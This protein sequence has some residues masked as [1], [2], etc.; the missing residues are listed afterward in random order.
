MNPDPAGTVSSSSLLKTLL[1]GEDAHEREEEVSL[2]STE[3]DDHGGGDEASRSVAEEEEEEVKI[4][5]EIK[6]TSQSPCRLLCERHCASEAT[7]RVAEGKKRKRHERQSDE[8]E[9]ATEDT[10]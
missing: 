4:A 10:Q 6:L 5:G 9:C 3:M 7:R 1:R 2:A 8:E